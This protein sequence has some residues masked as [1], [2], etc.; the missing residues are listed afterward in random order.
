VRT[1]EDSGKSGLTLRQRGGLRRLLDDVEN[2]LADYSVIL[3]YEPLG[4]VPGH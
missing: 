3:V 4:K 1:Y 2:G